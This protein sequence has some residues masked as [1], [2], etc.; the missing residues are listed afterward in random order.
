[1]P[2]Q[3]NLDQNGIKIER[4]QFLAQI[5]KKNCHQNSLIIITEHLICLSKSHLQNFK[6][7]CD[8][9]ETIAQ[10]IKNAPEV[11]V[12]NLTSANEI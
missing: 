4:P 2:V 7:S 3:R 11:T 12:F 9:R 1:M 5:L 6:Q 10:G 8:K